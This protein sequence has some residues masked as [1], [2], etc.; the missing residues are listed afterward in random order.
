VHFKAISDT[1]CL[2]HEES[3]HLIFYQQ[4]FYAGKNKNQICILRGAKTRTGVFE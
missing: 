4:I 3:V 1:F 2:G